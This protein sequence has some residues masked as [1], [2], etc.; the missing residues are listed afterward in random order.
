[1]QDRET[2]TYW[3]IMTGEAIAG[4]MAGT[5]L[6]E[7]PVGEKIQWKDWVRKH[8]DTVVLSVGGKE[9]TGNVY[10]DYFRSDR[11]FRGIRAKD[12][13]LNDKQPVYAFRL[14]S[15]EYAVRSETIEGGKAMAINGS[16]LFFYRPRN[17]HLFASTVAYQA[18]S[19]TFEK[20]EEGWIHHPSGAVFNPE[21]GRFEREV[22]GNLTRLTGL[23][24]YWFSW[25][26]SNPETELIR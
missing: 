6:K 26:L 7:L 14:G 25:S 1:M 15:K 22:P 13:R 12:R 23:D 20:T 18:H 21:T 16:T 5:P 17:A 10:A 24:T 11:G 2:D 3:S 19:G 9:D 4:E 8:P